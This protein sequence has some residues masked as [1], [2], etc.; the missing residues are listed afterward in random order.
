MVKFCP[1]CGKRISDEINYCPQCG[2]HIDSILKRDPR[3]KKSLT[4]NSNTLKTNSDSNGKKNSRWDILLT[5]LAILVVIWFA[6]AFFNQGS[7]NP[8]EN[9]T[10]HSSPTDSVKLQNIQSVKK[11]VEDYHATHT[12]SELDMYVCGDMASDVW[13]MVITKGINAKIQVGNIEQDV[14]TIQDANHAW[15]LAEVATDEWIALECTAGYLVCPFPDSCPI[16]NPRYYSGWSYA[17]PK[18]FK[19]F[20]E[21]SRHPCPSGSV[22]G[23]DEKCHLACGVNTYCTGDSVCINGECR[24]CNPG[25]IIGQDYNCHQECPRGSGKYCL[26]S[27]CHSDGKCYAS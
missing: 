15:V 24:G 14:S 2:I 4:N 17:N 18:E 13:N 12:Y 6:F 16:N 8:M 9:S 25:Y 19:E 20:L 5:V 3:E 7:A 21:E 26:N 23:A 27:V 22:L 11:I 1:E 10:Y